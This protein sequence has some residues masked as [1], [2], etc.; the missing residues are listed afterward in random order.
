MGRTVKMADIA[1]KMNVSVVTVSKALSG[2]K[3]V[4]EESRKRILEL[5]AKMGYEK[6]TKVKDLA[7]KEIYVLGIVVAERYLAENQSFYW[8]IYQEIMQKAKQ[9]KSFMILEVV[10]EED[11]NECRIPQIIQEEKIDGLIIMGSFRKKYSVFL[12]S[13][14]GLP[15]VELDASNVGSA[16]DSVVFNNLQGGYQMTNYLFELGHKKIGFVGTRLATSSIDERFL[17]YLKSVM[18]HGEVWK[19]EWF[20][21]DRD[22]ESGQLNYETKFTL[23]K[24]MPTAFFC[25]CDLTAS[26]MMRKLKDAGYLVPE[27]ISVVGFDDFLS[28]QFVTIGLTTYAIDMIEMAKRTLHILLHKINNQNY[29]TGTF[30][31]AGKLIERESAKQIA[32]PIP[33]V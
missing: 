24:D 30:V 27:D 19:E 15:L 5:A 18:E 17:G 6:K 7:K 31:V 20:I 8:K 10:N 14:L 32:P 13:N 2:Q 4:S 33:F 11:E 26:F 21:D 29:S 28:E 1:K 12:T 3:G 25:N 9:K 23:P 22:R 16:C